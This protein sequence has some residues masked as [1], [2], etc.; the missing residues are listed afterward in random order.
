M[1]PVATSVLEMVESMTKAEMSMTGSLVSVG[2]S[3]VVVVAAAV[4]GGA[5]GGGG[6]VEGL[7]PKR[8]AN[9][10]SRVEEDVD[11]PRAPGRGGSGG[12]VGLEGSGSAGLNAETVNEG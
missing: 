8:D 7:W 2:G 4:G 11:A 3:T 12:L 6:G 10:M 5:G 1:I 9:G